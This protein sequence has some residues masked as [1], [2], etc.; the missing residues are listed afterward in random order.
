MS[1]AAAWYS[2][3]LSNFLIKLAGVEVPLFSGQTAAGDELILLPR[4][5]SYVAKHDFGFI[6]NDV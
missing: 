6:P 5:Y 2:F 3:L 4:D 1:H